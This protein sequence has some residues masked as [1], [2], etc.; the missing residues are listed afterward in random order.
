MSSSATEL[1]TLPEKQI[2]PF[3]VQCPVLY[4]GTAVP[5][6]SADP[7]QSVQQPLANRYPIDGTNIVKGKEKKTFSVSNNF[8]VSS[9]TTDVTLSRD[10]RID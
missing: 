1:P 9:S 10:A 5:T 3:I 4:L 8:N 6:L 7:L 2:H